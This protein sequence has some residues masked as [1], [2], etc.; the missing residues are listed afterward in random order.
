MFCLSLSLTGAF[1]L[2]SGITFETGSD[3]FDANFVTALDFS[4]NLTNNKSEYDVSEFK[5]VTGINWGRI[6][7]ELK[8]NWRKI[9]A[10]F[11]RIL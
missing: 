9:G 2:A 10:E 5:K 11:C 3:A 6:D 8:Q 4:V 7:K 1:L